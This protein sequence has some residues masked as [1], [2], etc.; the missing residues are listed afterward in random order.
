MR[1]CAVILQIWHVA[2]WSYL[3]HSWKLSL[4]VRQL[5]LNQPTIIFIEFTENT[6]D[7]QM[8]WKDMDENKTNTIVNKEHNKI[9]QIE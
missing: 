8:D 5:S 7:L 1:V 4:K 6:A 3:R 9:A 2:Y